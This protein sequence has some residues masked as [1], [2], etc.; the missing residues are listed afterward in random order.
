MERTI[1]MVGR[2]LIRIKVLQTLYAY[3]KV[4][5]PD[6]EVFYKELEFSLKKSYEQYLMFLDILVE[7][8]SHAEFRITQIQDRQLKNEAEW[9]RLERLANNRVLLQLENN[10]QFKSLLM[11]MK[12]SL[13]KYQPAFKEIFKTIV[14]S[15]FYEEYLTQED[16]YQADKQLIRTALL[17]VVAETES[18]FDSFEEFSIYWNDDIDNSVSMVEKTLKNFQEKNQEGGDIL[19][20]FADKDTHDFGYKLFTQAVKQWGEINQY[21]DRNLKNWKQERVAEL[22]IVIMQLAITEMI[23]FTEIPIPVTMNEYIELAKW[24]ST[25][26][27]GQFV[28]GIMYKVAED[29]KKEGII[30]KVGRGLIEKQ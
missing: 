26:K 16:S 22:D 8:R 6:F 5:K 30:K 14:D 24:Y 15:E 11:S 1:S 13:V 21:I 20:M 4:E 3:Q 29:L 10:P 28:N 18:L 25:S 17:N 2:H 19:P 12:I 9:R 7:L 23:V 27:S